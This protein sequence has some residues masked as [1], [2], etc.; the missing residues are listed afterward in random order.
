MLDPTGA[1]DV[2]RLD[3]PASYR[4]LSIL[5]ASIDRIFE[6]AGELEDKEMLVFQVK[7]AVHETCTNI[8]DHA[9][10]LRGLSD[11]DRPTDRIQIEMGFADHPRRFVADL[12]DHGKSFRLDEPGTPNQGETQAS[13]YGLFL[14]YKLISEIIY[15]PSEGNNHWRLIKRF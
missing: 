4:F 15:E 13:G 12:Y 5:A 11:A 6:G 14:I 2:I 1:V 9:Y 7:L 3:L 8:I 10:K